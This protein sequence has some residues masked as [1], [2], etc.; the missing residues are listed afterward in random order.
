MM[1]CSTFMAPIFELR[2]KILQSISVDPTI[3]DR[4]SVNG[5]TLSRHMAAIVVAMCASSLC[6]RT[7]CICWI[8]V[9]A[10]LTDR[11]GEGGADHLEQRRGRRTAH[12]SS[13]RKT[14]RVQRIGN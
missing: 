4:P 11:T 1:T 6:R 13:Q 3:S 2:V 7:C 10:S 8:V 14:L 5:D 12:L 9:A